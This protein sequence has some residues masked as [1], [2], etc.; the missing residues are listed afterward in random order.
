MQSWTVERQ[1][2]SLRS[3]DCG[4]GRASCRSAGNISRVQLLQV[5]FFD[6]AFLRP[7]LP[8][9]SSVSLPPGS[10]EFCSIAAPRFHFFTARTRPTG[11]RVANGT[12]D[13]AKGVVGIPS[14][15]CGQDLW[16]GQREARVEKRSVSGATLR[17]NVIRASKMTSPIDI[18]TVCC[19]Y[20]LSTS[21]ATRNGSERA[22]RLLS[23]TFLRYASG[24]LSTSASH[25][26]V[27]EM[28]PEDMHCSCTP[29]L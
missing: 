27:H 24:I 26:S 1:C 22:K 29:L 14:I 2:L 4:C 23:T 3:A 13:G 7:S 11:K 21:S 18:Q 17:P 5:S 9:T 20:C 19:C 10:L 25:A 15:T 16:N 6:I 12:G 28:F 8:S